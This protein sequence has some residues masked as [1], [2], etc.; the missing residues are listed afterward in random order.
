MTNQIEDPITEGQT[1]TVV[2]QSV[3][4]F[5]QGIAAGAGLLTAGPLGAVAS[6]ATIRGLQGKWAPWTILGFIGAPVCLGVQLIGLGMFGTALDTVTP[7]RAPQQTSS[8]EQVQEAPT[9]GKSPSGLF[10]NEP[11]T[12]DPA[13]PLAPPAVTSPGG[14]V[15]NGSCL[16]PN[17]HTGQ[18]D[19]MVSC[20]W[21]ERTNSNGD[22]VH[23]IYIGGEVHT[24]VVLWDSGKAEFFQDGDRYEANWTRYSDLAVR[25]TDADG[26]SF[27]F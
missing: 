7:N 25:V 16:F 4:G 11:Q 14:A 27:V 21:V 6:W 12:F 19:Q 22:T 5:E 10:S 20:R 17:S 1:R 2:R 8:I 24:S 18:M 13:P 15:G 23:D 9:E 3:T 26:Y